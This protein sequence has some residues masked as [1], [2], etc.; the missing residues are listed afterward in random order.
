MA[1]A[2]G[3]AELR[4]RQAL[5]DACVLYLS[6]AGPRGF[7]L[8]FFFFFPSDFFF[9]SHLKSISLIR[10]KR[11]FNFLSNTSWHFM[12]LPLI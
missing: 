7:F 6:L 4:A 12:D 11:P 10:I 9:F 1:G 5:A 3:A 8:S 2:R